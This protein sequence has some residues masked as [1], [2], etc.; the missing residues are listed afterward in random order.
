MTMSAS[1]NTLFDRMM[2]PTPCNGCPVLL[3]PW[4][5]LPITEV[6]LSGSHDFARL[7]MLK[8]G[9]SI[10]THVHHTAQVRR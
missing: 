2:R 9:R 1:L 4:A 3:E 10:V 6:L 5:G 8:T 7:K